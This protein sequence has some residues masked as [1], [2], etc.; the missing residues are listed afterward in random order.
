[1]LEHMRNARNFK[2]DYDLHEWVTSQTHYGVIAEFGVATGRTLNHFA[3]LYPNDK[4]HG[5]DAFCSIN[6]EGIS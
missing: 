1:M 6:T 2:T 4:I 5:F 3:K